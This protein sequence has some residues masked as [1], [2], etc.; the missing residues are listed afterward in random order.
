MKQSI[1]IGAER[2]FLLSCA[3]LAPSQAVSSGQDRSALHLQHPPDALNNAGN[4][5]LRRNYA[6][7]AACASCHKEQSA[8]YL[9]TAH[10][11][12]SQAANKES[13]LGSFSNRQAIL[14]IINS[15][16]MSTE[17]GLYFKMEAK[18]GGYYETAVTD[19]VSFLQTRSERID[20]VIGSGVHGQSYLFWKGNQLYE[21]PV[22]Y[23]SDGRQWINSPGYRDGT[24]DFSRPVDPRCMECHVTY[25][26]PLSSDPSNNGY[27]KQSLVI[28]ISCEICHGA[29]RRACFQGESRGSR[30]SRIAGAGD[31][32]SCK[33]L[34]R[35]ASRTVFAM[36]QR[37][38][39]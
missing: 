35:Q 26:K 37:R 28:G 10:H 36:P 32:E 6:G 20:I 22:S 29:G 16:P 33:I 27:D 3:F 1:L 25:I 24:A 31:S 8:S 23:W 19:W 13:I 12:T 34:P 39:P 7:D 38:T 14:R 17:P 2:A 30:F 18:R 21:A 9:H 15:G 4:G 11:L 5:T